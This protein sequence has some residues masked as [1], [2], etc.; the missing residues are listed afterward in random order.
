M[1]YLISL[2]LVGFMFAIASFAIAPAQSTESV[3]IPVRISENP[4]LRSPYSLRRR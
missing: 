3:L 1:I 2:L 4:P